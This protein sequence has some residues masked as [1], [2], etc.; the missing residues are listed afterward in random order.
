VPAGDAVALAEAVVRVLTDDSMRLSM[1][2]AVRRRAEEAFD[3]RRAAGQ[4]VEH[5]SKIMGC[6]PPDMRASRF[7]PAYK[8]TIDRN[9]RVPQEPH[10]PKDGG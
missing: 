1:G 2:E 8:C 9:P 6:W 7:R 5:Y 10:S 4:L 3:V